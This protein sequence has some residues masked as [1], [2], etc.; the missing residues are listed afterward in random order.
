MNLL[1]G[2]FESSTVEVANIVLLLV[3]VTL[4][5]SLVLLLRAICR[6]QSAAFRHALLA[7][8][9]LATPVLA[10][11]HFWAP[12]WS[13]P[14]AESIKK[15][16]GSFEVAKIEPSDS[17][18]L[19]IDSPVQNQNL[20]SADAA[21]EKDVSI[22]NQPITA[23]KNAKSE[24]GSNLNTIEVERF[25]TQLNSQTNKC[26]L[27]TATVTPQLASSHPNLSQPN[28]PEAT[29]ACTPSES[30]LAA[31]SNS[32]FAFYTRVLGVIWAI[33]FALFF[34]RLICAWT[35]VT[36]SARKAERLDLD[37]T[38]V[39]IPNDILK[40]LKSISAKGIEIKIS[41]LADQTPMGI[42]CLNQTMVLPQSCFNWNGN[43]WKAVVMHEFAHF[44]RHDCLVNLLARVV[45]A[46]FWF[47]PL[48]WMFVH[49]I[50]AES[51]KACDDF[52][53]QSG[54]PSVEYADVLY[55]VASQT[56]TKR[57]AM[58]ATVTM[59]DA[60]P[61]ETRIHSILSSK[62]TRNPLKPIWLVAAILG[63]AAIAV[64]V[65]TAQLYTSQTVEPNPS[66]EVTVV[67]LEIDSKINSTVDSTAD[68]PVDAAPEELN[69]K[70][71]TAPA[72]S[73]KSQVQTNT[74]RF[75]VN[76]KDGK[77][78]VGQSTAK[79]EVES[80]FGRSYFEADQIRLI[81]K[82]GGKEGHFK[83]EAT[84]GSMVFGRIKKDAV[85]FKTDDGSN[86]VVKLEDLKSASL[87]GRF[88]LAAEKISD[89]FAKNGITYHIRPPKNYD[90]AKTYPAIVLL[91]G[92]N[93]NSKSLLEK[94]AAGKS[95]YARDRYFLIG[96]NGERKSNNEDVAQPAFNY[97]YVNFA[98]KSTYKGYPGTDR[99]SPAL[100][101]EVI[102]EIKANVSISNLFVGGPSSGGWL[103]YSMYMN[104]PH[105]I[106]GAFP[107]TG[108][109]IIQCEPSAYKDETV[110]AQQ[111]DTPIVII[112]PSDD[113]S[114]DHG[115]SD[116]AYE[117]F[118]DSGFPMVTRM[119]APAE[120][121]V[122]AGKN[123]AQAVLWLEAMAVRDQTDIEQSVQHLISQNR[124]RDAIGLLGR[125]DLES[126][127]EVQRNSITSKAEYIP[128]K[129]QA[130][131][132]E[133]LIDA[134]ASNE[135][136]DEFL[137]FRE[138]FEF[139]PS[140]EKVM[141][142]FMALRNKHDESA[143]E[144]SDEARSLFQRDKDEEAYKK[145]QE[146]V[147]KFYASKRYRYAKKKLAQRKTAEVQ[148]D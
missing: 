82:A 143:E 120:G 25:E 42:G 97:T 92:S 81:K 32:N 100:V 83:I 138:T 84:D 36:F 121:D 29:L 148:A 57:H 116:V 90:P 95:K 117:R 41:N 10:G 48:V 66:D 89:G 106:D 68:L 52:V 147:D 70:T 91:H 12:A 86:K 56:V 24:F 47:H 35:I 55:F 105:L 60:T 85:T 65:S 110:R 132:F 9:I 31:N 46:V 131:K 7:L 99:E 128:V 136:I 71:K 79:I 53:I 125:I 11:F 112:H 88:G 2:L 19:A 39:K 124:T 118:K 107:I 40:L 59:S 102:E 17:D 51:E 28:L 77:S 33:G 8:G 137:K 144:I 15:A 23:D 145:C 104:Y 94:V 16:V 135:W 87:V 61:L 13:V 76:T 108:A 109:M 27:P 134:N 22:T 4:V 18:Q 63:L 80:G 78:F 115:Y 49:Q 38:T 45:Q 140:A 5:L 37:G 44:R 103:S 43:Q 123:F 130:G 119:N 146:I 72:M 113:E 139:A 73:P 69:S 111:R 14:G 114:L 26:E 74:L 96:I 98:G 141:Q 126:L 1:T 62:T 20:L 122:L 21:L 129:K 75:I 67:D 58:V 34:G 3:K 133:K 6:R 64:P 30:L 54:V 93:S 101:A 142:K 127:D 50:R